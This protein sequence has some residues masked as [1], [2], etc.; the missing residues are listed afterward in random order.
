MVVGFIANT[1]LPSKNLIWH[2]GVYTE[3]KEKWLSD[4]QWKVDNTKESIR[5][6][7][8]RSW[9]P[10]KGTAKPDMDMTLVI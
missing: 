7:Y 1:A 3:L 9:N 2:W 10:L 6:S 8:E 5:C 4:G